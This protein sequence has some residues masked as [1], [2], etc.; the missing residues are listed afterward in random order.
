MA[1]AISILSV[2]A[3]ALPLIFRW[4]SDRQKRADE[5][6]QEALTPSGMRHKQRAELDKAIAK[7]DASGLIVVSRN[8]HS[9]RDQL[10]AELEIQK[11]ARGGRS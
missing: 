10:R 6:M 1:A 7:G 3:K 2:L 5:R 11:A 8:L 4:L 9:L